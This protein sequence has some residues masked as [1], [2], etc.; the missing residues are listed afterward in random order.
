MCDGDE[1]GGAGGHRLFERGILAGALFLTDA[2]K[3][4][5]AAR[6]LD[7]NLLG[8]ADTGY[9]I[10][11][12]SVDKV[13]AVEDVLAGGGVTA[14]GHA[15]CRVVAHVAVN[16][17]L[18]VDGGAPL[19]GNLVHAAVDDSALVHPAVEY[20]AD[21]APELVPGAFGEVAAGKVLDSGL[22]FYNECLEV[23]DVQFDVKLDAFG[24]LDL[25][26][27]SLEGVDVSLA[28][29]LHAEYD[30]AVHLHETAVA[31]PGEAGVAAHLGQALYGGV[32][33]T[34]V[35]DGVHHAGHRGAGTRAYRYEEGI[36][37]IVEFF[38]GELLNVSDGHFDVIAETF[39]HFVLTKL[40]VL[41]AHFGGDGETGGHGHAQKVHLGQVG[42]F[43]AKE[44][45]HRGVALGV[46]VAERIN[47]FHC[48]DWNLVKNNI[49]LLDNCQYH[50]YLSER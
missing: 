23:L 35:E 11:T 39:Y 6:A 16:H 28:L 49:R 8:S 31:V 3:G 14:E 34:Q 24:L 25:F 1:L 20:G 50:R 30:V 38:A 33:H 32:V 2:L 10:L 22:E 40:S 4:G 15:R 45:A 7:G 29:G 13:F 44:V 41:G 26:H 17:S 5:P 12:L 19:F 47:S 18:N 42:A 48:V 46:S 21:A 36:G 27:D 37:G 9:D 43:T